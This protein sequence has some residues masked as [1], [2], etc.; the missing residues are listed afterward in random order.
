[1]AMLGLCLSL[2]GCPSSDSEEAQ[3][4]K[5]AGTDTTKAPDKPIDVAP[6]P[7]APATAAPEATA[8]PKAEAAQAAPAAAPSGAAQAAPAAAPTAPAK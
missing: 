5:P 4:A 1:M 7:A 6:P 8:T 3:Q 2:A